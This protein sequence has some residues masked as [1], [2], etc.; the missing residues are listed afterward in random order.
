MKLDDSTATVDSGSADSAE[1]AET[2][3]T[4]E[5]A[6]PWTGPGLD[7]RPSNTTCL[8]T[9]RPTSS[10]SVQLGRVFT[11]LRFTH[12]VVITQ[13]PG[14]GSRFY[15]L[16]QGGQVRWFT[17]TETASSA[18]TALDIADELSTDSIN[19]DGLLGMAFDPDFATNGYLYLNYTAGVVRDGT[20]HS[21]VSR[22]HSDDDGDTFDRDSETILLTVDQPF[23]NHDGGNLAFGPDGY[24]YIGFGDG[25]SG[26]D[27]Y[28]NGQ[29]TTVLLGKMLRIDPHAPSEGREYGIPADNPFADGVDGEPEIY[30]W[31]LRNPWRYSF[32]R[33]SGE[34]WVGD[35]GQDTYEEIDVVENGGDYGWNVM[36]GFHCYG[37]DTCDQTGL[38]LPVVEVNHDDADSILGGYVYRGLTMPELVGTYLFADSYRGVFWSIGYDAV[39]GEASVQDLLTAPGMYPVSMGED[40]DG[41]LYVVDWMGGGLYQFQPAGDPVESDFP[42]TLSA[43]GCVDPTDATVAASGMIPYDVNMPLWSDGAEKH[44][45]LAIPDGTTIHAEDDG[46]FTLPIGSVVMK[47]FAVDGRPVETRLLMRHEDG[48]WGGY[49]Y[50]WNDAGTDADLLPAGASRV[51]ETQTWAYPSR[52]Q[53]LQCHTEVAGRLLGPRIAQLN[54]DYTYASTGHTANQLETMAAIGL[55]D[56]PLPA[57][58]TLPA[59]PTLTTGDPTDQARAYLAA[60]CAMCHVPDGP[61]G[62]PMDFRYE[63]AVA[64]MHVCGEAPVNGDLGVDGLQVLA[65]GDPSRS[66]ISVRM[67][68]LDVHRM[69]P[70]G[71]SVVDDVGVQL[72]DD[73]IRSL[74]TCR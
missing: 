52:S 41:E 42:T 9:E 24:L 10:A 27:P 13:R 14:D 72:V 51:L 29:N 7:A 21:V 18:A 12:P 23:S 16:E 5:T 45:W 53:C 44:R 40:V 35:V 39:T 17:N 31:G 67:H 4:G 47:E 32:D 15:V 46:T 26:G 55:L 28:G 56:A 38:E 20:F 71:S 2:A 22:V 70:I 62:G 60:N 65:P 74:T 43:T 19:E 25:G 3:E 59:Y 66:A 1:T 58:D 54:G 6:V 33:E 30:A 49:S 73:W 61:G 57:V 69:P 64:D 68:A 34:L 8:A 50:A 63:T 36:E 48:N 37:R 11:S